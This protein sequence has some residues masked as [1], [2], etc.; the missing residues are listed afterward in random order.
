MVEGS[1]EWLR[2]ATIDRLYQ[3]R[4]DP[5]VPIEEVAGTV[6]DLIAEGK[7]KHFG[8]SAAAAH[9]IRAHAVQP[10]MLCSA[11]IRCGGV[12]LKT[13]SCPRSKSS[14]LASVRTVRLA[15]ACKRLARTVAGP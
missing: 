9:T 13:K 7:A 15:R 3:H 5:S 6:K 2:V 12:A 4:V 8:P 14:R 11:S 1:L 10:V